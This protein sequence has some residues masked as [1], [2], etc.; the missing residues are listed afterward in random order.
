MPMPLSVMVS[1]LAS[2]SNDTR[3]FEFGIVLIQAAVVDGLKTQLVAGVRRVGDQFAQENFLVGVQRMGDQV[4]QL[5]DFGLKGKGLLA[6]GYPG[7]R[8]SRGLA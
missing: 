3:D 4:Q 1:V 2:L 5:C 6:H 7:G 8:F